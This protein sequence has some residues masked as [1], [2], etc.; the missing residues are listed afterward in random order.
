VSFVGWII[1]AYVAWAII[2]AIRKS[3]AAKVARAVRHPPRTQEEA[4]GQL[5]EMLGITQGGPVA[6]PR[7]SAPADRTAVRLRQ[8]SIASGS[9]AAEVT[10]D[11]DDEAERIVRQRRREVE[12]RNRALAGDDHKDFDARIRQDAS[13]GSPAH[14]TRDAK[15]DLRKLIIWQEILGRPVGERDS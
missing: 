4:H 1:V 8:R 14:E 3:P 5:L 6:V 15:V 9:A 12:A 10:V 7:R 11:H 2:S 13:A